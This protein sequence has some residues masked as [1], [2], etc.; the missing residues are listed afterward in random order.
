M[1]LT[2]GFNFQINDT[3]SRIKL[4]IIKEIKYNITASIAGDK[5]TSLTEFNNFLFK[6]IYKITI[7]EY[8]EP[9]A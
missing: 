5:L 3:I 8:A 6:K 7:K 9:I 2:S 1:R 4:P